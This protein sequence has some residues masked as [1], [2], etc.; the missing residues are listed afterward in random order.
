MSEGNSA[1]LYE[2]VERSITNH[3]PECGIISVHGGST[4]M[5]WHTIFVDA[6]GRDKVESEMDALNSINQQL[7]VFKQ[8]YLAAIRFMDSDDLSRI[9]YK[10]VGGRNWKTTIRIS[11]GY[12]I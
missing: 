4:E 12:K 11:L 2:S 7:L 1:I 6:S 3:F 9:G 8:P 10:E 5:Y